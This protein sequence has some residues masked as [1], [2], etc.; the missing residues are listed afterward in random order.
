MGDGEQQLFLAEFLVDNVNIPSIR[1]MFTEM[2]PVTTCVSFQILNLPPINVYQDCDSDGCACASDRQIFKKGKSCLFALP[3]VALE[4][5]LGSFPV[6]M[7]VYK[8]LPPGVLPDV[9][10]IGSHQIEIKDLVNEMLNRHVFKIGNPCKTLRDTFKL[11]TATGQRVGEVTVFIRMSC[12]GEKIVT[13]FQIPHN[14]KPYLFKGAENSPVFQ[15]KRIPSTLEEE[16]ASARCNCE[17]P[18]EEAREIRSGER[19]AGK[20]CCPAP[21]PVP[22][23]TR[24]AS[25]SEFHQGRPCC[26]SSQGEKC[27]SALASSPGGKKIRSQIG[28]VDECCCSIKE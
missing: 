28:R 10:I 8:K 19:R 5:P 25:V 20:T 22:P 17:E 26:P 24:Q 21:P 23:T 6:N 13:Q 15:C 16:V 11:T 4:K 2:L 27:P 18:G 1:A 7:S 14:Q 3:S 12:F 9:M